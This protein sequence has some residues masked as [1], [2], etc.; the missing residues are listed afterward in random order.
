M[1]LG[2][3]RAGHS[4]LE[5]CEIDDAAVAVLE[6]RFRGVP[7]ER[8]VRDYSRLPS[9]T[10]LLAAGFPCQDLSQ[11]G[12]TLGLDGE[13]SSLIDEVFWLLRSQDV[14]WVLLENVSFMLR[15]GKGHAM[16]KIVRTFEELGYN[17]AYRIVDSRA[18]GLPQRRK[19]VFVLA[20][21][22]HDPRD[23]LLVDTEEP[24]V[25]R[26]DP[27]GS[28]CGFY[29]TEGRR[30][31]GW[32]VDGVPT[33]KG[34]SSVGIPSPPAIWIPDGPIVTPTI[35][36]AERLQGFPAGWTEPAEAVSRASTRWRLVGNAVSVDVAEWIGRRLASPGEFTPWGDRPL[37][38]GEKWPDAAYNVGDGRFSSSV[39]QYPQRMESPPLLD[40]LDL[41]EARPLS[42]RAVSGFLDRFE[43]SSLRRPP[44]FM[45]ALVAHRERMAQLGD[46]T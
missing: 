14:P 40:F 46:S 41:D 4:T 25:K 8:D 45:E 20:S 24:P 2:L 29:W 43:S 15:L 28:A 26:F 1:E 11:A 5:F 12:K 21:Q 33:L 13:R 17:W 34:G 32:A 31:L 42:H 18:F 22:E 3:Q 35:T 39:S 7:I 37:A 23:V 27:E 6:K 38:E 19:R 44:G 16:A 10:Q 36:D 30:G 9:D